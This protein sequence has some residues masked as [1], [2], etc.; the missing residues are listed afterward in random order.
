MTTDPKDCAPEAPEL[1]AKLGKAAADCAE[2]GLKLDDIIEV[3][4]AAYEAYITWGKED[5]GFD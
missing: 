2:A 5:N 3:V 1:A 4:T